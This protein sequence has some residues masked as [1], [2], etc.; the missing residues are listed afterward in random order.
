MSCVWVAFKA[1]KTVFMALK[2]HKVFIPDLCEDL[3]LAGKGTKIYV[4][5]VVNDYNSWYPV[6]AALTWIHF[7]KCGSFYFFA[8]SFITKPETVGSKWLF[9]SFSG[10]FV[11]LPIYTNTNSNF[12]STN[13]LHLLLLKIFIWKL[14]LFCLHFFILYSK[15]NLQTVYRLPSV[16]ISV[17]PLWWCHLWQFFVW[18][19]A[20]ESVLSE[21]RTF[22]LPMKSLWLL[23]NCHKSWFLYSPSICQPVFR[24]VRKFKVDI[25]TCVMAPQCGFLFYCEGLCL[26]LCVQL[27]TKQ[28]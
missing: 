26:M 28:E 23:S 24:D 3:H 7:S 18:D 25:R 10:W 5:F 27:L 15:S 6:K 11:S 16:D 9:F 13:A 17:L 19:V 4:M 2:S 22:Q 14:C 20:S 1:F 12:M 8:I 21:F